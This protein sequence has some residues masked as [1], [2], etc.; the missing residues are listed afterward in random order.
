MS[1]RPAAILR[2][3]RIAWNNDG[4]YLF[5]V[6]TFKLLVFLDKRLKLTAKIYHLSREID[7]KLLSSRCFRTCFFEV[8]LFDRI[9]TTDGYVF[10]NHE[11]FFLNKIISNNFS[12]VHL[13]R[14]G[15]VK[16]WPQFLIESA[17]IRRWL[18]EKIRQLHRVL[19][20]IHYGF[21][22]LTTIISSFFS[23]FCW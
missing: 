5:V 22:M 17:G 3:S 23:A 14:F 12:F 2:V 7:G 10:C 9:Q 15:M 13:R 8:N 20:D 21:H 11:Q 18:L 16:C 1:S 6:A 4:E 19:S